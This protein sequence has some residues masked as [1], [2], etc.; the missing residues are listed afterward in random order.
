MLQ[1]SWMSAS[2]PGPE[3]TQLLAQ[4]VSW[5][6]LFSCLRAIRGRFL[7]PPNNNWSSVLQGGFMWIGWY[8]QNFSIG[9]GLPWS[10]CKYKWSKTLKFSVVPQS[11][12]AW[13]RAVFVGG[14][15]NWECFPEDDQHSGV[16]HNRLHFMKALKLPRSHTSNP[17]VSLI[18]AAQ[19]GMNRQGL[20]ERFYWYLL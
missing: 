7:Q 5:L 4:V 18:E 10:F 11:K 8:D 20:L 15:T 13:S 16:K 3:I 17:K 6:L 1:A 14:E 2:L 9:W 12:G 19:T